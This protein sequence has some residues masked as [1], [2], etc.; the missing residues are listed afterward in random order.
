MPVE[1]SPASAF[2]EIRF[3]PLA[4]LT[5]AEAALL[6]AATSLHLSAPCRLVEPPAA[7]RLAEIPG[8]GQLDADRL[9]GELE[10]EAGE[11]DGALVGLVARDVAIPI[12]TFV[13]GRARLGG[14]AAVVSLARLRPEFYGQSSDP[15]LTHRRAAAEILHELGHLAGLAHCQDASCLMNFVSA[16]DKVDLRGTDFCA[17]CAARLPRALR[18]LSA[19]SPNASPS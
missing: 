4:G 8:R 7:L 17:A 19:A 3:A 9:L 12:F 6:V 5:G 14:R 15:A 1:D 11:R 16:V 18:P 10:A 2:S 13:F